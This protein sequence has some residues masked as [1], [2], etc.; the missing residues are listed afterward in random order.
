VIALI[1]TISAGNWSGEPF[2]GFT[3]AEAEYAVFSY[4]GKGAL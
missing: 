2:L 1:V 3:G 4:A